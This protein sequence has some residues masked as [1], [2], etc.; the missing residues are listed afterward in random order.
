M[1]LLLNS[2]INFNKHIKYQIM[3]RSC[4]LVVFYLISFGLNSQNFYVSD[5]TGSDTNDGS[6][7]SPFK[8][9]NKAILEVEFRELYFTPRR[10]KKKGFGAWGRFGMSKNL[11][12][13]SPFCRFSIE[14]L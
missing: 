9:I 13:C 2:S 10:K 11:P 3:I 1:F 14:W 7:L 6:E 12:M 8:T 5:G 4:V